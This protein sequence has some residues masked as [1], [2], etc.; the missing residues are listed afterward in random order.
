VSCKAVTALIQPSKVGCS[1]VLETGPRAAAQLCEPCSS[2]AAGPSVRPATIYCTQ[3][4]L[5]AIR[6]V[7]V[8]QSTQSAAAAL[9]RGK[10]ARNQG[11]MQSALI[12]SLVSVSTEDRTIKEVQGKNAQH[13]QSPGRRRRG[14]AIVLHTQSTLDMHTKQNVHNNIKDS[15]HVLRS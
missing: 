4:V 2:P 11:L 3:H 5:P 9:Q 6:H 13:L 7:L 10:G 14:P 1:G 8:C 15:P 12:V